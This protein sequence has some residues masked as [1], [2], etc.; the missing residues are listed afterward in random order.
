[1]QKLI[2]GPFESPKATCRQIVFPPLLGFAHRILH[3][4]QKGLHLLGP[5]LAVF[6]FD[7]GQLPQMVSVAQPVLTVLVLVVAFQVIVDHPAVGVLARQDPHLVHRLLPPLRMREVGGQMRRTRHV[8]P[9]A[10]LVDV[11]PR[12]V[13]VGNRG[14][15]DPFLDRLLRLLQL[16]GAVLV[17]VDERPLTD[18]VPQHVLEKLLL[19][20]V[21]DELVV[22]KVDRQGLQLRTVLDG[23]LDVR[24]KFPLVGMPTVLADLDLGLVLGDL[25]SLGREV[26]DLPLDPSIRSLVLQGTPASAARLDAVGDDMVRLRHRAQRGSSMS[27][28]ASRAT[29]TRF[30]QALGRGPHHIGG[31]GFGGIL[32]VLLQAR[33][34]LVGPTFGLPETFLQLAYQ[35]FKRGDAL[36]AR[37]VQ[38][39]FSPLHPSV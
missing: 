1:M 31:R 4:H 5:R 25:D 38:V 9:L 20:L 23:L 26:E 22:G 39:S 34:R 35:T 37:G 16:L 17:D 10:L 7:E 8:Q 33:L 3:P 29:T 36:C 14:A 21:R 11:D 28:L 12:F 30:S 15:S 13:M 32:G 6:F 18:R 19:P 24:R 2:V 27:G